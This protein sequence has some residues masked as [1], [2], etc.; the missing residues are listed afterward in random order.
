MKKSIA[1]AHPAFRLFGRL[2]MWLSTA[3]MALTILHVIA[4][5]GSLVWIAV[6]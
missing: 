3:I 5:L 1:Q 4:T 6:R 2:P